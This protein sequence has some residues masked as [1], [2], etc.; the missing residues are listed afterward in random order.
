VATHDLSV[1]EAVV[2]TFRSYGRGEHRREWEA[3]VLL[4]RYAPGLA[5]RPLTAE[6]DAHPPSVTMSRLPGWPLGGR[7][8]TAAELVGVGHAMDQLHGAVPAHELDAVA[9]SH[10]H[11]SVLLP[12]IRDL[13]ATHPGE[14]SV[15]TALAAARRWLSGADAERTQAY[16]ASDPVLGREDHNL[17]NFLSD[18]SRLRLVDFEDAGRSDRA[19]EWA[20]LVE[21]QAARCTP[22]ADWQ[23]LLDAVEDRGRLRDARRFYACYWLAIMLPGQRGHDLNPPSVLRERALRLLALL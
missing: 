22:D 16:A 23:P 13:L 17:P 15:R 21:H 19:T 9:P 3:L 12:Q 18:G 6:L 4:D 20:T 1:G 10:A 14:P 8:L 2:K 11:P 7:P 5:P